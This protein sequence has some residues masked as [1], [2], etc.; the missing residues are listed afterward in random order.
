VESPVVTERTEETERYNTSELE[1]KLA[2]DQFNLTPI[3]EQNG[4]YGAF[5]KR[6]FHVS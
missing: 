3:I 6:M 5:S 1:N 4:K 2:S